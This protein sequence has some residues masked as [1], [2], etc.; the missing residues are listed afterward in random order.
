MSSAAQ[1]PAK[2]QQGQHPPSDT[3]HGAASYSR[4][5]DLQ[6]TYSNYK[7]TLQQIAQRIGDIEQE[8]EEHKLV[9]ETL[10]PLSEDRKCFRLINGVLVERTVKDVVPALKTN[11]EGLRKVLDDLVKQYKTKQD[12]LEKW[13]KKNNVQ[14]VQQ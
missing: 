2:K 6:V 8:A 9:L 5:L 10:E 14:V 12:D 1:V 11:Q 3:S 4:Y 7:N 13:K